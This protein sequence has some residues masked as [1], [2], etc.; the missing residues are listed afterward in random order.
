MVVHQTERRDF[1]FLPATTLYLPLMFR[2]PNR[3]VRSEMAMGMSHRTLTHEKMRVRSTHTLYRLVTLAIMISASSP[4]NAVGNAP[5]TKTPVL[6]Q[7]LTSTSVSLRQGWNLVASPLIPGD[8]VPAVVFASIAG[9][10]DL[11]YGYDACDTADPWKEYDPKASPITND[12]STV[13][14]ARG[15]W[16][17]ATADATWIITGTAPTQVNIALCAG[18]NLIGYPSAGATA[19]PNA[20]AGIGGKYSM[21]HTY[22][23]IDTADP[24]KIFDPQA[25]AFVND[26]TALGPAKGYWI[27]MKE[28]ATLTVGAAASAAR[29]VNAPYLTAP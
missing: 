27:E 4:Y 21:V 19:L 13:S 14:V 17:K 1:E 18:Q 9:R 25:P 6:V 16:I 5:D 26:L 7:P 3:L 23:S 29:K 15:L 20:L 12:L 8:P 11:V 28:S 24:W 10:F 22:D 2:M